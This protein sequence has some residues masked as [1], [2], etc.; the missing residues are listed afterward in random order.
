MFGRK[1]K[2]WY[3]V[4]LMLW[5]IL[6]LPGYILGFFMGGSD[7]GYEYRTGHGFTTAALL[8]GLFISPILLFPLGTSKKRRTKDQ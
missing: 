4:V 3:I 7:F 6:L 5:A 8:D 2:T 1:F